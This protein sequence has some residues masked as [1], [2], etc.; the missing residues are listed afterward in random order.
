MEVLLMIPQDKMQIMVE[1]TCPAGCLIF[2]LVIANQ[3]VQNQLHQHPLG[4]FIVIS[5]HGS[6]SLPMKC[7][8]F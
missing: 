4:Q 3:T 5:L 8:G 1:A 7:F 2:A 6:L